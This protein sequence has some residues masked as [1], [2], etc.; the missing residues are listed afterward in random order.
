ME[1][2]FDMKMKLT[3]L[4]DQQSYASGYSSPLY[5]QQYTLFWKRVNWNRVG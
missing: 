1:L 3:G 4:K 2:E 5:S